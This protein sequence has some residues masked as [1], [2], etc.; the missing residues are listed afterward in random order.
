MRST[1]ERTASVDKVSWL[2]LFTFVGLSV[3]C[4]L[5][6]M[7]CVRYLMAPI[8]FVVVGAFMVVKWIFGIDS[9]R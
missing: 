6:V 7:L 3:A 2:T 9:N 1:P 5:I 8:Y 4:T